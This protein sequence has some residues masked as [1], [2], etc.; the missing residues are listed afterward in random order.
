MA[1]ITSKK[2]EKHIFKASNSNVAKSTRRFFFNY[3]HESLEARGRFHVDQM[4]GAGSGVL[5]NIED[6]YFVLTARHVIKNN[7]REGF[8]NESPFWLTS[9]NRSGFSSIYDFLFPKLIWN[10]G[11]LIPKID[12]EIDVSDICLVELFYPQK[13]HM[14]DH[15]IKI[16]GESSVMK[17]SD[18]FEGQFLLVTGYPF[19]R[20]KFDF[21]SIDD[22][23]THSTT[24]QRHTIPG[25]YLNSASFGYISFEMTKGNTQHENLNG[26][27]GGAIYNIQPKANMVKLAGIPVTAGD[28]ICRFIPSYLFINALMRYS[29]SNF[30]V[31]D[32]I[33]NNPP[34]LDEVMRVTLE[35]LREFDPNFNDFDVSFNKE[36]HQTSR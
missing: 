17:K 19:E 18:F 11:E 4:Y 5:L 9:K 3:Q 26:M 22:N 7:L 24:I 2:L 8:Q 33:F 36:I 34:P 1:R 20:N 10:I 13:F 29:Q 31:V 23:Y 12:V 14:P 30:T 32:P 28:N 15:F 6:K 25:I 21:N 16:D 27:S 35:Y